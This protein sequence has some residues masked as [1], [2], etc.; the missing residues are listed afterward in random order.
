MAIISENF[1]REYW[2]DADNALGKR[3][4]VGSNDDWREIVGVVQDVHYDGV[5]QPA[6][7]ISLLARHAWSNFE[8]Q[9]ETLR[10]WIAF[11]IR[12]PRAGS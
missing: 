1:A 12:S 11:V 10:R 7:T 9:K 6:P 3:I 5:D 2:H 8:G 4:R